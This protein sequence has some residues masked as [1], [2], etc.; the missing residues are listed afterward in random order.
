MKRMTCLILALVLC[1]ALF[2]GCAAPGEVLIELDGKKITANMYTFW[3]SRYK[4]F[5]V[6]SYMNNEENQ[7]MW[8]SVM[9]DDGKTVNEIF[10]GYVLDNARTYAA[11]L[12][13]YD[14]YKLSLPAS[15]K[16]TIEADLEALAET[17]GGKTVMNSELANF[18]VNYDMLGEIYTIEAKVAQLQEYMFADG[19]P[20]AIT[21]ADRDAYYTANYARIKH[22]FVSTTGKYVLD[23]EGNFTYDEDGNPIMAEFT[24]VELKAQ[25]E[26]AAEVVKKL[27]EG[28]DFDEMLAAYTEDTATALYPNGYYFTQTST[29]VDEIIDAAFEMEI[30]DWNYVQSDLGYHIIQRLELD[31]KA[32]ASSLDVDFFTDFESNVEMEAFNRILAPYVER[33]QVNEEIAANY[34]LKT[35]MANY[36]Y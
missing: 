22:I 11:A 6:Y 16:E 23:D 32:Y 21:D 9:G 13:L 2:V 26:K 31:P 1:L 25:R 8:D 10:T 18:G 3:L 27:E 28:A 4:A 7:Q 36:L 17:A 19:G 34:S 20:G 15:E 24:D 29:Y 14:E 5:F 35:V 12:A 33:A 30:G